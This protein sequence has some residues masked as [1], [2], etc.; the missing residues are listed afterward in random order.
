MKCAVPLARF[1][2]MI[3]SKDPIKNYDND[4][5]VTSY[6]DTITDIKPNTQLPNHIIIKITI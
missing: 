3:F 6:V 4:I 1:D 5:S 2:E